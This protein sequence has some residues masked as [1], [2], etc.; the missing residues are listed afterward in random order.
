[1]KQEKKE[2]TI[3]FTAE[4]LDAVIDAMAAGTMHPALELRNVDLWYEVLFTIADTVDRSEDVSLFQSC[5]CRGEDSSKCFF[6]DGEKRDEERQLL[7]KEEM[8]EE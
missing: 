6:M 2:I 5:M 1:M 7:E 8:L 3:T 4:E